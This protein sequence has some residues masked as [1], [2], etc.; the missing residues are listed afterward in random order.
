MDMLRPTTAGHIP[1][2]GLEF[3]GVETTTSV[4]QLQAAPA[5]QFP[6]NRDIIERSVSQAADRGHSKVPSDSSPNADAKADLI[7]TFADSTRIIPCSEMTAAN[8][9][10]PS[11]LHRIL[12]KKSPSAV[13]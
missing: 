11:S 6:E 4:S 3:R 13:F 7:S 12:F 5:E 9:K 8:V 10:H 2:S 1:Y